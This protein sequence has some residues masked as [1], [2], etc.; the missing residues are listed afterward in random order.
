MVRTFGDVGWASSKERRPYDQW[1]S[2]GRPEENPISAKIAETR[3][4][5]ITAVRRDFVD[6]STWNRASLVQSFREAAHLDDVVFSFS[7]VDECRFLLLVGQRDV[8]DRR[9]TQRDRNVLDLISSEVRRHL[10]SK[11]E[12]LDAPSISEL[13]LRLRGTL[14]CLLEGDSEKQ[15]AMRTGVGVHAVHDHVKRLHRHFGVS[16]RGELLARCR[17]LWPIL[18]RDV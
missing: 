4:A 16:S 10:G 2:T 13:P 12:S 15:A 17:R 14:K 8:G 5:A 1:V 9:F 6:D 11:L 7:L 18:E 3:P